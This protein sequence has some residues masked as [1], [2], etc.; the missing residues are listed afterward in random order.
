[1]AGLVALLGLGFAFG[2]YTPLSRAHETLLDQHEKLAKKA[3]ELDHTLKAKTSALQGTEARRDELERFLSQGA[4]REQ[5]MRSQ[6]EIAEATA[7]NQLKAFV[8]AKLLGMEVTD[9]GLLA[10]LPEKSMFRP[11]S[12][13]V[14]PGGQTVLCGLSALLSRDESWRVRVETVGDLKDEKKYW[15]SASGRAGAVATT[16]GSKCKI[17]GH[18]IEVVSTRPAEE[19]E[20]PSVKILVG[21]ASPP[22]LK[23]SEAPKGSALPE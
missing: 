11:R 17:E 12:D 16:L 8:K 5:G 22:R 14:Q 3:N 4:E 10:S 6:L 18:K 19:T 21:P 15:E 23:A 13:V 2:Y 20:E 9:E 1:M 7:K